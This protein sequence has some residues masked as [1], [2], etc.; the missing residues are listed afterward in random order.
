MG[1]ALSKNKDESKMSVLVWLKVYL[2]LYLSVLY[3]LFDIEASRFNFVHAPFVDWQ[4]QIPQPQPT[5][6][7]T[8][9]EKSRQTNLWEM[10]YSHGKNSFQI[11]L[12]KKI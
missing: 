5:Y 8:L 12:L 6:K 9:P 10:Y 11:Y 1:I 3:L 4:K 7:T 2:Y